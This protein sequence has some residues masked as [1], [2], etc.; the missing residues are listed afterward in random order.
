MNILA[1][2]L[3]LLATGYAYRSNG[4]LIYGT[5]KFKQTDE[6][7][8]QLVEIESF[9]DDLIKKENITHCIREGLS[10]GYSNFGFTRL[11][12]V[13]GVVY[14]SLYRNQV[15]FVEVA[16]KSL[17]KLV[18]GSGK[19]T[20]EEVMSAVVERTGSSPLDNNQS[21]A[22]GLLL[23]GEAYAK[24]L[25]LESDFGIVKVIDV[26]KALSNESDV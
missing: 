23:V 11:S 7:G 6:I 25:S 16:P 26:L 4:N 3:S 17:K 2:D 18:A 19:A 10:F 20:K 24:A 5:L 22:I 13:A 1:L 12:S 15:P 8:Y 14:A 9:I 21:D